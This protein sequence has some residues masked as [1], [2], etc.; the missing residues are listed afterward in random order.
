MGNLELIATRIAGTDS[1]ELKNRDKTGKTLTE[2]LELYFE[3]T[4]FKGDFVL[5]PSTS[6]LYIICNSQ[7]EPSP[8]KK[9][10]IYGE[11]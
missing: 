7:E 11:K 9:Y 2:T 10:N 5:S 1:W 6:K 3:E 4:K 8:T